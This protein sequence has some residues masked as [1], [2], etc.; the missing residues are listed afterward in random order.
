VITDRAVQ[1]LGGH[2]YIVNI[3]LS[4]GCE[5]GGHSLLN[6]RDDLVDGVIVM[7]LKPQNQFKC[8]TPPW[9]PCRSYDAPKSRYFD[10]RA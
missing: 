6:G 7:N 2:G 10:G 3:P 5:T 9:K 8:S 1:V 4:Y